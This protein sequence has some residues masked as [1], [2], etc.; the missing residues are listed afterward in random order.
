MGEEEKIKKAVALQY[1]Q[2][3]DAA[4]R[5]VAAGKGYLAEKILEIAKTKDV[6][7]YKDPVL[8]DMLSHLD[9]GAEIPSELYSIVAEVLVFVYSLDKRNGKKP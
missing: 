9:L 1:E 7:V 3:I 4:P 6:P 2:G 5:V 8:V